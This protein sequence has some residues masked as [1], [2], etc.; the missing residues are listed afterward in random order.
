MKGDNI[1]RIIRS[2]KDSLD[3]IMIVHEDN[4]R[5]LKIYGQF[6]DSWELLWKTDVS[7]KD[8]LIIAIKEFNVS[9]ENLMKNI[10]EDIKDSPL[11]KELK[12]KVNE[13]WVAVSS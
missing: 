13:L 8:S 9:L 11:I 5:R 7:D 3:D 2:I 12:A 6:I 1:I 10:P 4:L